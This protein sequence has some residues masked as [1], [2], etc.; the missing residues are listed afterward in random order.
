MVFPFTIGC[1]NLARPEFTITCVIPAD[2]GAQ[3]KHTGGVL[4]EPGQCPCGGSDTP[5]SPLSGYTAAAISVGSL[6][7]F[8]LKT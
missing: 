2:T 6:P 1:T 7:R 3:Y 8:D 4:R 5:A